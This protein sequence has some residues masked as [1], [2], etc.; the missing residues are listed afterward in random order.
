[1]RNGLAPRDF[2]KS[3]TALVMMSMF[4]MPRLP[5]PTAMRLPAGTA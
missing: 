4:E 1:M 2:Q 5:T 3:I